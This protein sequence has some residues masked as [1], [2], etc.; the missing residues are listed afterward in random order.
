[1]VTSANELHLLEINTNPALSM[2]NSTLSCILPRLIDGTIQLVL[3]AQVMCMLNYLCFT[4][5]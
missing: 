3:E 2:D 1:M 4:L 5:N